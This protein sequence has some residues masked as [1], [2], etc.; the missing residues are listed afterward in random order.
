MKKTIDS[1]MIFT[2]PTVLQ[3]TSIP[4]N[5]PLVAVFVGKIIGHSAEIS[6]QVPGLLR[7]ISH[8]RQ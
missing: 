4:Q 8:N 3:G 2:I 7:S 1:M 6:Q 5:I